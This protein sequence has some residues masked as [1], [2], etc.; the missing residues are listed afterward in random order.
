MTK[1]S[2]ILKTKL[3]KINFY[4]KI[5]IIKTD[6][7][8]EKMNKGLLKT[9]ALLIFT[10]VFAGFAA[11]AYA[12][13]VQV[14]YGVLKETG[15]PAFKDVAQNNWAYP[16]VMYL[17]EKGVVFG[18]P[19]G[20]YR[21][22]DYVTR[23]EFSSMVTR[24]LNLLQRP[25]KQVYNYK[26]VAPTY[27]AYPYIQ[28]A[29]NYDLM[30]G[31]PDGY[32]LPND[33]VK[34]V[35]VISVITNAL[36]ISELTPQQAAEYLSVYEDA[37]EI[38]QWAVLRSA[39]AKQLDMIIIPPGEEKYLSPLRPATR[40]ELAGF[41]VAMMQKAMVAPNKKIAQEPKTI[42]GYVLE[43]VY[44]DNYVAYIPAGTIIPLAVM[45]CFSAEKS[46]DS[47]KVGQEGEKFSARATNNFVDKDKVLLIP[48][49]TTFEGTVQGITEGKTLLK[50]G[51]IVLGLE[52][53]NKKGSNDV[54]RFSAVSEILPQRRQFNA[55]PLKMDDFLSKVAYNVF[56]DQNAWVHKGQVQEFI[57]LEPIQ[58]DVMT[59]WIAE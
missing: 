41:L 19:D 53:M 13:E 30:Q 12:D 55:N 15:A 1:K 50:N 58:I 5:K 51:K 23:A 28:L 33:K 35:E 9:V 16:Y 31:A 21:P 45:D 49:G 24:A 2:T 43:N 42:D 26:D 57:L 20:N 14:G 32:F 7:G 25:I 52:T 10:L 6:K 34:R 36:N 3:H 38:P 17:K 46:K 44:I 18:Y 4:S 27:W 39:K 29:T 11:Q 22:D 8:L 56:R 48:I 40:G 37:G 54:T 47:S 59:N